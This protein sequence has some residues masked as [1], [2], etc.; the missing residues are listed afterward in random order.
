MLPSSIKCRLRSRLFL[1]LGN[2][3]RIFFDGLSLWLRLL[4]GRELSEHLLDRVPERVNV[5]VERL[6]HDGFSVQSVDALFG[7][8]DF[9][10][11]DPGQSQG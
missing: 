9:L 8:L 2:G 6:A 10:V 4:L 1:L 11:D 7:R 5:S 3:R